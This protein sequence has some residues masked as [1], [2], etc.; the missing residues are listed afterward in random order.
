[1][2]D[3]LP[4]ATTTTANSYSRPMG[5]LRAWIT[6][7]VVAHHSVLAYHSDAPPMPASLDGGNRIW[8]AFPI[9]DSARFPLFGLFTWANEMYFMALMFLLSGLFV[10]KWV[11]ETKGVSLE[12]MHAELLHE[13]KSARA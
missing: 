3:S 7:L 13:D 6:L 9:V 4:A 5:Y 11:M 10:W 12:D 8:G 2:T 1:M